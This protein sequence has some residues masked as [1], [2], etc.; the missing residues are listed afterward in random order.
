MRYDQLKPIVAANP[1]RLLARLGVREARGR[2]WCPFCQ[3]DGKPHRTP[4]F[5]LRPDG[6]GW[7]CHRC[8]AKGD[9]PKLVR[10]LCKCDFREAVQYIAA[11]YGMAEHD[12]RVEVAEKQTRMPLKGHKRQRRVYGSL[13]DAIAA[14][15]AGLARTMG[16]VWTVVGIWH[17]TD[18]LVQVRFQN[19]SD[20]EYRPMHKTERGW[21]IGT[22]PKPWPLYGIREALK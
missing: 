18:T 2:A 10:E 15:K 22:P 1:W 16:G 13:S 7:K 12:G 5:G 9:W 3:N 17:Y 19:G 14:C 20:K 4:D 21:V 6:R 8:G 11:C